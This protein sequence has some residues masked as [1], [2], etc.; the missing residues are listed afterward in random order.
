VSLLPRQQGTGD[1][2]FLFDQALRRIDGQEADLNEA[3][4][5]ALTV[6]S[7]GVGASGLLGAFVFDKSPHDP[8]G[9][10]ALVVF[11]AAVFALGMVVFPR[12]EWNFRLTSTVIAEHYSSESGTTDLKKL[13]LAMDTEA[14]KNQAKLNEVM[15]SMA[16]GLVLLGGET[17]LWLVG[18][19]IR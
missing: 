12:K 4:Q 8:L 1:P 13:A 15:T 14:D 19:A 5:R 10:A 17:V 11:A 6:G 3:R 18:L 16:W 2:Q 7:F 9:I